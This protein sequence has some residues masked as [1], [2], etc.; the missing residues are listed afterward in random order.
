MRD[1]GGQRAVVGRQFAHGR[2][3]ERDDGLFGHFLRIRPAVALNGIMHSRWRSGFGSDHRRRLNCRGRG[4]NVLDQRHGLQAASAAG[5]EDARMSE[6]NLLLVLPQ[7]QDPL[8]D[9]FLHQI[10]ILP[11]FGGELFLQ[12]EVA[13]AVLAHQDAFGGRALPHAQRNRQLRLGR[14]VV[15]NQIHVEGLGQSERG[16]GVVQLRIGGRPLAGLGVLPL[17]LNLDPHEVG[18]LQGRRQSLLLG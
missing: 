11:L 4:G 12:S 1:P 14:P 10:D 5:D 3:H 17:S 7:R 16:F 8:L 6:A 15:G 18:E 2:R 9:D 13:D